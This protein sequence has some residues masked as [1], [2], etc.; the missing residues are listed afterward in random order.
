MK[1]LKNYAVILILCYVFVFLGGWMLFD[2]KKHLWLAIAAC[3]FIFAVIV[4]IF[5]AQQG[6]IEELEKRVK[7]LEGKENS[8]L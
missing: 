7:E 1:F 8:V 4:T 3:A 5:V 6:K 2:F